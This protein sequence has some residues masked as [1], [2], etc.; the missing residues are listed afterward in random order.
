M[1]LFV[2]LL[3]ETMFLEVLQLF[4]LEV[5]ICRDLKISQEYLLKRV[6]VTSKRSQKS[7]LQRGSS[8][9]TYFLGR[10]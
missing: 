4:F 7:F 9:G 10:I 3:I 2:N 5:N 1:K 6:K 8:S